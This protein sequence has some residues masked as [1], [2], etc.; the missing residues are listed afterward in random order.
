MVPPDLVLGKCQD[1]REAFS[2]RAASKGDQD[3]AA[4]R[5]RGKSS[6]ME[7]KGQFRDRKNSAEEL[8]LS[9]G[10]RPPTATVGGRGALRR[11]KRRPGG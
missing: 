3:G 7:L 9:E 2:I 6:D 10:W 8:G 11:G 5:E 1:L 4:Q